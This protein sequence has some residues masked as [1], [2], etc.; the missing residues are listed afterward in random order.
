MLPFRH[1]SIPHRYDQNAAS[2]LASW[3]DDDVSI[4]HRYDQN[5][6]ENAGRRGNPVPL[7]QFL[8]GTIKTRDW[9]KPDEPVDRVSIPHRYDQNPPDIRANYVE[10]FSFNS[11]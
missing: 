7:F 2:A 9:A 5:E 6:A 4:P 11:S 10:K 8:I 3:L 1:V